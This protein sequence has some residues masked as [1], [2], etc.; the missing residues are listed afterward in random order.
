MIPRDDSSYCPRTWLTEI[1]GPSV[2]Y[3]NGKFHR[4][5]AFA[6]FCEVYSNAFLLL[7]LLFNCKIDYLS[8]QEPFFLCVYCKLFYFSAN[9]K[10]EKLGG[11]RNS[12]CL[13][14]SLTPSDIVNNHQLYLWPC[15]LTSLT[16]HHTPIFELFNICLWLNDHIF[17]TEYS[18]TA[19]VYIFLKEIEQEIQKC[20]QI[21]HQG[22]ANHVIF[23]K[24]TRKLH[25]KCT[26][27]SMLYLVSV[28]TLL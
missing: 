1:Q 9:L 25:L 5:V 15:V 22:E 14:K 18:I 16:F 17:L 10:F 13:G 26:W 2:I 6:C 12:K 8:C 28:V 20:I 24:N 3:L 7:L 21:S 19:K 23:N 27:L 11:V 4:N